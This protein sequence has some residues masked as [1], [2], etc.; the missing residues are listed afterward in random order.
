L[1]YLEG[2]EGQSTTAHKVSQY[3]SAFSGR[4]GAERAM[5]KLEMMAKEGLLVAS[6][7][8]AANRRSI[9]VFSLPNAYAANEPTGDNNDRIVNVE[10]AEMKVDTKSVDVTGNRNREP[11]YRNRL[12]GI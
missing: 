1:K 9:R 8:K 11:G 5:Q 3:V 12:M 2:Q 7:Q 10:I 4:G 6:V